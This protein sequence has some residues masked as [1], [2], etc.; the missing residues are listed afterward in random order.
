MSALLAFLAGVFVGAVGGVA[1][2]LELA[3]QELEPLLE[4][5]EYRD[6]T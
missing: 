6:F 1:I 2:V 4:A 5:D 3:V